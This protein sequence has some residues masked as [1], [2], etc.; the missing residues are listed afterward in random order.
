MN[1]SYALAGFIVC[2]MASQFAGAWAYWRTR[3]ALADRKR[4][5]FWAAMVAGVVTAL[6]ATAAYRPLRVDLWLGGEDA[7]WASAAFVGVCIGL[8]QAVLVRGRPL[9][10]VLGKRRASSEGASGDPSS[11]DHAA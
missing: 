6:V 5:E 11:G 10:Q 9:T 8:C 1:A 2:S 7:P 3:N 4:R